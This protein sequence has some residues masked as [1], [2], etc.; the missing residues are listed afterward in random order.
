MSKIALVVQF[1]V[2]PEHRAAFLSH[3]RAHAAA[4]LAEVDG[5]LQ[6]DVLIPKEV[7]FDVPVHEEDNKRVFLYEMYR[8]DAA[9]QAHVTSPRVA[10]TRAGYASM[11]ESRIITRCAVA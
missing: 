9:F 2:K 1:H 11:I 4:T 8:D 10:K 7:R 5:C 3:M 6:F